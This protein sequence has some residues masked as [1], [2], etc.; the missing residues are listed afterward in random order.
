MR[1]HR[2]DE[3]HLRRETQVPTMPFLFRSTGPHAQGA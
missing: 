2:A 1:E 3:Q